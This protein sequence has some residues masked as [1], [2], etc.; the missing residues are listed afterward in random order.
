MM[1]KG[2]VFT[3]R[4]QSPFSSASPASCSA[5]TPLLWACR[6]PTSNTWTAWFLWPARQE[7][8]C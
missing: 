6:R 2:R 3:R 7:I 4:K 8:R 1:E 5:Y